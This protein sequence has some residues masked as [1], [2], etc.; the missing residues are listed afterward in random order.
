MADS[1]RSSLTA[2]NEVFEHLGQLA[3]AIGSPGRLLLI[4]I[5]AQGPHTVEELSQASNQS[6][7]NTSQHLQ[8]LAKAGIVHSTK[9][10]VRRIYTISDNKVLV[11]WEFIQ[12]L[13]H[14]LRPELDLAENDITAPELQ[15][16]LAA[17]DVLSLVEN[18]KA[19][20]I[21]VRDGQDSSA[22]PVE[23]AISI[24]L[25]ELKKQLSGLP[26]NKPVYV[27]CRGRYCSLAAEAVTILRSKGLKAFRL[28]ESSFALNLI[29]EKK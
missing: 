13:G 17:S 9:N 11:I 10:G 12:E 26:K 3:Q 29:L 23:G 21:D 22:T 28:R 20:L 24:P 15:S 1:R 25:S 18:K 27:F 7:A 8:R 5:L 2:R 4:Q 16:E 6:M 19:I 14:T